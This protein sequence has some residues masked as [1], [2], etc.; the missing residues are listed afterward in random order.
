MPINCGTRVDLL[1]ETRQ[2]HAGA[3]AVLEADHDRQ[4]VGVGQLQAGAGPHRGRALGHRHIHR[5]DLNG[6]EDEKGYGQ[7]DGRLPLAEGQRVSFVW[8]GGLADHAAT[9]PISAVG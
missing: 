1:V 4:R 2:A 3:A 9:P 8:D 6:D 5:G 7:A